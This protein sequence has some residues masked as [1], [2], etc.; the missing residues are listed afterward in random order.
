MD[1]NLKANLDNYVFED[2]DINNDSVKQIL[3]ITGLK[4]QFSNLNPEILLKIKNI[5]SNALDMN[6]ENQDLKF[7]S[8]VNDYPIK[9]ENDNLN[10]FI[11]TVLL[12]EFNT[13]EQKI[14]LSLDDFD[15]LQI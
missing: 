9:D 3:N 7:F 10:G 1:L 4:K 6:I 2:F 12:V 8:V 11:S 15:Y 5:L 13:L 14:A